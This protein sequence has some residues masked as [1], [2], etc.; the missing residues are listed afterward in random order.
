[1][2]YRYRL[3]RPSPVSRCR[4]RSACSLVSAVDDPAVPFLPITTSV[5]APGAL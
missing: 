4:S 5:N 1:M 2:A 3:V